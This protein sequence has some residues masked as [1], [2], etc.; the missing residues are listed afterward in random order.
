MSNN[1]LGETVKD[2]IPL[3]RCG[4][5]ASEYITNYDCYQLKPIC[6]ECLDS[7][8]KE[9]QRNGIPP[10]V[11]TLKKVRNMCSEKATSLADS[12]DREI[13]KIGLS[14]NVSPNSLMGKYQNDL[15]TIRRKLHKFIDDYLDTVRNDLVRKLRGNQGDLS[16][17]YNMLQEVKQMSIQLRITARNLFS[18]LTLK[19]LQVS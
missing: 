10:E 1:L 2:N 17:L 5:H 13:A 18:K 12:L 11:D 9:N 6:P 4:I 7:H 8:L 19:Q 16:S 3:V 14:L 15:D